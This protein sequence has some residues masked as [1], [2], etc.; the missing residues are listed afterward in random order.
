MR[1]ARPPPLLL[2]SMLCPR[3]S[4][5]TETHLIICK[6]LLIMGP[7]MAWDTPCPALARARAVPASVSVCG[8]NMAWHHP[9]RIQVDASELAEERDANCT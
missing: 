6:A 4:P 8:L 7:P 9:E 5:Q 2:S 1:A 3:S